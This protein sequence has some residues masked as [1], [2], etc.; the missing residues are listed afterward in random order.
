ML[1]SAKLTKF[2][3]QCEEKLNGVI[4]THGL[5]LV[6]RKIE[7]NDESYIYGKIGSTPFEIFIY[8]DEAQIQGEIDERFEL[9]DYESL[10]ELEQAFLSKVKELIS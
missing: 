8:E 9:P 10:D 7:G 6:D 5:K 2:Q 3:I 1:M 4:D